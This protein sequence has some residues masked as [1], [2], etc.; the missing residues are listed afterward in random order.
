MKSHIDYYFTLI[1]DKYFT[2]YPKQTEFIPCAT[3]VSHEYD[4]E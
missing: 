3:A 2:F 1:I 4:I